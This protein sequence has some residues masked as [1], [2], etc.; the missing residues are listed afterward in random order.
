MGQCNGLCK[1]FYVF[2]IDEY[3]KWMVMVCNYNVIDGDIQ[4]MFVIWLFD[5]V[6]VV[7]ECGG[8]IQRFGYIDYVCIVI[9]G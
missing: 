4:C 9:D 3:F 6:G 1:V 5:F 8:M 7:F 2:G